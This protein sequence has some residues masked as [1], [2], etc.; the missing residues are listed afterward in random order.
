[1]RNISATPQ[2]LKLLDETIIPYVTSEHK[3]KERGVNHPA[4]SLMD[5]FRGQMTDSVIFRIVYSW[6]ER[7]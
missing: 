6:L 7:L 4:V 2:F 5:V 1:M 3:W